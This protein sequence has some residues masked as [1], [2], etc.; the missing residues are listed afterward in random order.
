MSERLLKI[1][2]FVI[3]VGKDTIFFVSL[4][5]EYRFFSKKRSLFIQNTLFCYKQP[6]KIMHRILSFLL[7]LVGICLMAGC[8]DKAEGEGQAEA[9]D[10]VP[11]LN[12]VPGM[13]TTDVSMLVSD[14]GVIRYHAISP[15]WYRYDQ[16][17]AH[18]YW[19]F[20]DGIELRQLD[21][22]LQPAG[23][24]KADTAYYQEREQLWHLIRNVRIEN[25]LGERFNTEELYW[26]GR[27]QTIYSDSF[28]HIERHRDILEGYGFTSDQTF[29]K[30]EIRRTTGIF[31]LR[32]E[33]E[34]ADYE[35]P[36][37]DD[38]EHLAENDEPGTIAPESEVQAARPLTAKEK[39]DAAR[40]RRNNI[41]EPLLL[42]DVITK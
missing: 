5:R 12:A 30:Y 41:Q 21:D 24:I 1:T 42:K 29:S 6:Q 23:S 26:D 38:G 7:L 2:F 8:Q 33:G 31:A 13:V 37:P 18:K 9:T 36:A 20:P 10:S 25:T 17:P 39:A 15:I 35:G 19:Y 34:A 4:P 16:D 14:S 27:R 32:A 28:I 11:D 40:R 3:Y 22:S